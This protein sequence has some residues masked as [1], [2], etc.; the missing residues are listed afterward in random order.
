MTS[1]YL[2]AKYNTL[3][4]TGCMFFQSIAFPAEGEFEVNKLGLCNTITDS[5]PCA[6]HGNGRTP[7]EWVYKL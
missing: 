4:D 7:M 6:A 1:I 2:S 5:R 3:L